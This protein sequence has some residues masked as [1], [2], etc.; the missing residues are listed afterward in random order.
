MDSMTL[1][2]CFF[3]THDCMRSEARV[4][5]FLLQVQLRPTNV[6]AEPSPLDLQSELA[7]KLARFK[8]AAEG[9]DK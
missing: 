2:W 3:N 1:T 5:F 7:A 9:G 8:K 4:I 6:S